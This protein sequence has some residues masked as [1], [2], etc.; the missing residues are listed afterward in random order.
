MAVASVVLSGEA[1]TGLVTSDS[2]RRANDPDSF[3]GKTVVCTD[4]EIQDQYFAYTG[5]RDD[6]AVISEVLDYMVSKGFLAGGVRY[7]LS[8]FVA[9]DWRSKELTQVG[10]DL[11][12][13][14]SIGINLPSAWTSANVWDVTNTGS[15]GGHDVS[16]CG[17]GTRVVGTNAD[18][19]VISSWGRL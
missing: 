5:G 1:A 17:Y 11:F 9:A 2:H 12:G 3:N 16:P 8:G 7:K 15:V 13:C 18:G 14:G 4:K 19:V 10:I 6:G